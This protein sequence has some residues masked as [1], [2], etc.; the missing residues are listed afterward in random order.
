M[1]SDK[2]TAMNRLHNLDYLRGLAA[3]GIM[4]FHY[5]SWTLNNFPSETFLARVG[6]YGVAIFYV[7]SGLTLYYV[8]YNKMTFSKKYLQ[9]FF[10]KRVLRIF[11]LMWLVTLL[12]I[13][14]SN[15]VPDFY[16]LFLNLSGLFGFI[17]WDAYFSTGV[18]SIGNEL[19]FYAFFPFFVL[20]TKYYK[21]VMILLSLTLF[22]FYIFL[23]FSN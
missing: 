8:Y 5:L 18:W 21:P 1:K 19:V 17:K 20:F 15:K 2:G 10:K 16:I 23:P 9:S 11:P 6:L 14:L 22:G 7:L 12:H 4:I 13:F 3:T